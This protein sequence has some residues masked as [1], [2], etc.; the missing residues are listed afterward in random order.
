MWRR[1]SP[2]QSILSFF[3]AAILL[4]SILL[5]LP[6]AVS[7]Y[8]GFNSVDYVTNLFTAASAVCV[9]GLNV[10]DIG[11]HF[12]VFG[13]LVIL[14]LIQIGALGYITFVTSAGLLLGK[15][16]IKERLAIKEVIDPSSFEGLLS[17]LKY[18][19]K[20]VIVIELAAAVIFTLLFTRHYPLS[21]SIYY[22][23][24]HSVSAF[25]N[26]GFSLFSSSFE[27]YRG[28]YA[29]L[30]LLSL[31]IIIGGLGFLA[32]N[33][34]LGYTKKRQ[35]SL[36]TKLVLLFTGIL[37]LGGA[38]A[39]FLFERENPA[40][41]GGRSFFQKAANSLFQSITARTAGFNALQTAS[42]KPVSLFVLMGLMFVGASPGGTGGGVKTTTV[43]IA[44]LWVLSSI[45][46][47]ESV[48]VFS[49][50]ISSENLLKAL[51]VIFLGTFVIFVTFLVFIIL[52][53]EIPFIKGL[54][55]VVSAY[56][57][58]GLS[59][60]I[61]SSLKIPARLLLIFAMLAGRIGP[62]TL[63]ISAFGKKEK[64]LIQYSEERVLIG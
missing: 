55:E 40:T 50:K 10:V 13:Q 57:T 21:Q 15:L 9:T 54:F 42:L 12:S 23:I 30:I 22:G 51:L 33:D 34:I 19:V 48:S 1:L 62:I 29:V 43:G 35:L 2:A 60:G 11:T 16:P 3:L 64:D 37:I 27:T 63:I 58:V 14:C 46:G 5:S 45:M 17:L 26:A 18:I 31:L 38:A 59:T 53:P 49:R 28:D 8:G 7:D 61:T 25:A 20:F 39:V 52:H 6:W 4:G 24:F 56:G 47:K 44:I 41:L 36:H 32:T